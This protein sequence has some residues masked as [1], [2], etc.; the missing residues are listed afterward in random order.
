MG[1]FT[2]RVTTRKTVPPRVH[3]TNIVLICPIAFVPMLLIMPEN[4]SAA[5]VISVAA[6]WKLDSLR[7]NF[8]A[9][10]SL[11][12]EVSEVTGCRGKVQSQSER[13]EYLIPASTK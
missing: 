6:K 11:R 4:M 3:Q 13:R 7:R 1:A 12:R 10:Q 8:E 9:C 2:S 5:H